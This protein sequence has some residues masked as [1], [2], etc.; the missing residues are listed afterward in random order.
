MN[1]KNTVGRG[2][3]DLFLV[4]LDQRQRRVKAFFDLHVQIGGGTFGL[5]EA[6]HS[7]EKGYFVYS[8]IT[9]ASCYFNVLQISYGPGLLG[10][11]PS[12]RG[13]SCAK[14]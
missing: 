2:V 7:Q 10:E 14:H 12:N 5:S 1:L 3:R 8:L 13:Y 6:P 9:F 11:S 4:L